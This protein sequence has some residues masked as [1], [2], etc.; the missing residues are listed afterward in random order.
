MQELSHQFKL[1]VTLRV[2]RTAMGWSQD[3]MA[4]ALGMAKTT[5][6]RAETAEGNLSTAQLSQILSLYKANGIEV[7]FMLGNDLSLRVSESGLLKAQS[8][9]LD[10]SSRRSDRTKP[11]GIIGAHMT[12]TPINLGMGSVEGVGSGGLLADPPVDPATGG[13]INRALLKGKQ[14]S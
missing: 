11:I 1:S 3:E 6:A 4:L 8:K 13:V 14:G 5:L 2:A 9:W 10:A 12:Q 7:E